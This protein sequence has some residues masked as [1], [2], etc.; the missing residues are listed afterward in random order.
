MT[1]WCFASYVEQKVVS[2]ASMMIDKLTPN[3]DLDELSKMFDIPKEF[4]VSDNSVYRWSYDFTIEG[5][6]IIEPVPF[7]IRAPI[8][9]NRR[10]LSL[11][12]CSQLL[13][14][15]KLTREWSMLKYVVAKITPCFTRNSISVIFPWLPNILREEDFDWTRGARNFDFYN[16]YGIRKHNNRVKME[17][18]MH[19]A[20]KPNYKSVPLTPTLVRD[21]ALLGNKL[22]TQARLMREQRVVPAPADTLKITP[23]L[24]DNY[25]PVALKEAVE[26]MR[27]Y[28]Y[29]PK[30]LDFKGEN[31]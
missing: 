21:T 30:L 10:I 3:I 4:M 17:A 2:T 16:K 13:P 12:A 5:I 31:E 19:A 14:I 7:T 23:S 22:F 8:P 9:Y 6:G 28:H 24:S 25:M 27:R 29:D 1:T 18:C 11:T 15:I 26:E 20:L